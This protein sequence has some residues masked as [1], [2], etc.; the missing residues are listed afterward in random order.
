M[1]PFELVFSEPRIGGLKPSL[2]QIVFNMRDDSGA[3]VIAGSEELHDAT[4]IFEMGSGTQGW[5]EIDY[6]ETGIFVDTA[7]RFV[8]EVV[9]VL[10]FTGSVAKEQLADGRNG[11]DVTVESLEQVVNDLPDG[12]RIGI[13]EFHDRNSEPAVLSELTTDREA[14]LVA[15]DGF[16]ESEFLPGSSRAWDSIE[17]ATTLFADDPNDLN[18]VRNIVLFSDGR[19]T[20]SLLNRSSAG[21]IVDTNDISLYALGIGEVFE[22]EQL[23]ELVR[24]LGGVY[25]PTPN[26]EDLP[27]QLRSFVRGL[28]GQYRLTYTTLR[29][30]GSYQ[31][32]VQIN[33][34]YAFGTFQT[35][36]VDV[37]SFYGLD[38]EGQL[39]VD[40]AVIDSER[41][42][43]Q[44]TVRALHIPR[45]VRR[46][47][48]RLDTEKPVAV[49]LVPRADGGIL[50]GWSVTGPDAQGFF[51]ASTADPLALGLTG[52]LWRFTLAQ[53]T[54]RRLSV[55]LVIDNAVYPVGIGFSHPDLVHFGQHI[56][57]TGRIAFRSTRDGNFEI[58]LMNSDGSEQTNLT[59]NPAGD[60][61]AT[62]SPDGGSLAFDSNRELQRSLYLVNDDGSGVT[63][64]STVS[65]SSYPARSPDGRRIAFTSDRD[66]DR[67][68]YVMNADGSGQARLT[69][70]PADDYWPSWSPDS[71]RILFASDRD[72]NSEV[73]VMND[74]GSSPTNLTNHPGNDFRPVWSPSG[75]QIAFYSLRDGN[76]E[77]YVMDAT[78]ANQTNLTNHPSDD[79]YPSWSPGGGH[80]AFT[81]FRDG[82]REIY[83]MNDDGAEQV[84]VTNHPSEDLAPVWGP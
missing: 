81:S 69:N 60:F 58:Y 9:F 19:D 30:Q 12:V 23:A 27:N 3:P 68:I 39:A 84:N 74:D 16:V 77:V 57:A 59:E 72:G 33:L 51:S 52:G 15:V 48:F 73:Y 34:P 53:F 42:Q 66:G 25:Y 56:V 18:I 44:V 22:E 35:A 43:A 32:Q 7:E 70:D 4:R 2:V 29:R 38:T 65:N 6:S 61:L 46:F 21:E 55:P 76:R 49:D 31:T 40:A 26:L 71:S 13:V 28:S 82:N 41:S 64:V 24:S 47:R 14:V 17:T 75:L 8:Q 20:S 36:A 10:D 11:V 5:E 83:V 37:A 1:P 78:G 67:E 45:N 63:A 79:W 50:T 80:I 62:W 54:E